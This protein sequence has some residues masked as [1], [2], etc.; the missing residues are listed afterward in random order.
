MAWKQQRGEINQSKKMKK[1]S[2]IKRKWKSSVNGGEEMAWR[3]MK[4]NKWQRQW[5]EIERKWR[6]KRKAW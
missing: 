3:K 2:K 4:E 6:K 5:K 1:H